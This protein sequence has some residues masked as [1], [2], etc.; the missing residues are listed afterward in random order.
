MFFKRI[1]YFCSL[2]CVIL[3]FLGCVFMLFC[4]FWC[5]V[6]LLCILCLMFFLCFLCFLCM[7]NH[8][9]KKKKKFKTVLITSFILLIRLTSSCDRG[10]TALIIL[11][12]I[13]NT[14]NG[15]VNIQTWYFKIDSDNIFSLVEHEIFLKFK[16]KK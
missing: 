2:I 9:V 16:L 13:W 6:C 15:M 7:Q 14:R 1:F 8:F 10:F 4:G 12:R 5:F 11:K 3:L